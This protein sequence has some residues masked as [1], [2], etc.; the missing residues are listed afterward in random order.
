M[1]IENQ[2]EFS[3]EY[4]RG[5]VNSLACD[6][7]YDL[8]AEVMKIILKYWPERVRAKGVLAKEFGDKGSRQKP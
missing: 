6:G 3:Y 5:K 8:A 4:F 2:I 1:A 7:K